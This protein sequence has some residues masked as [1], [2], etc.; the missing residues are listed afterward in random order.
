MPA[1]YTPVCLYL[2]TYPQEVEGKGE[3]REEH[4]SGEDWEI[5]GVSSAG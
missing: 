3:F 2:C 4:I 5:G 1:V